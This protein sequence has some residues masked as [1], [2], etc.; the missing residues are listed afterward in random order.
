MNQKLSQTDSQALYFVKAIAIFSVI[1]AHS[2]VID[3]TTEAS[4]M[5]TSLWDIFSCLSIGCFLFNLTF[6]GALPLD[7]ILGTLATFLAAGAMYL[8]RRHVWI[9]LWMPALFNAL[10]VGWEL[11]L[12]LGNTFWFNAFCVALGEAVV[13]LTLGRILWAVIQKNGLQHRLFGDCTH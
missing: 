12:Y 3:T 1:A 13:L 6:A 10:L 7:P 4:S 11:T 8:L 2:S 5:I 9:A